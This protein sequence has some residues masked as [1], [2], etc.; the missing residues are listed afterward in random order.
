MNN[1]NKLLQETFI[2]CVKHDIDFRLLNSEIVLY[3]GSECRGYF[4]GKIFCVAKKAPNWIEVFAHEASHL[5][6]FISRQCWVDDK[7]A[8]VLFEKWL[9]K[10]NFN[11][12]DVRRALYN[13][14]K[15]ELDCEKRTV[16]KLK[17]YNL[18]NNNAEYIQRANAY[19]FYYLY[20]Y[21]NR[22]WH[23]KSYESRL[24]SRNMPERFLSLSDYLDENSEFLDYFK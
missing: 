12:K 11:K 10:R 22:K 18:I 17:K 14:I 15:S 7:N 19:L 9:N 4:D 13:L 23:D 8:F 6:Q 2:K 24:I 16:R 20:A 1:V 3:A 5:D 21:V